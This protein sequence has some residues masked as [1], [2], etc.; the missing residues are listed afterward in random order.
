MYIRYGNLVARITNLETGEATGLWKRN[1]VKFYSN[2]I[3]IR[4]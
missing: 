1:E 2:K 4:V 3:L